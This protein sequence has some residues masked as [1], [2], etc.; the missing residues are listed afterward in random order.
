MTIPPTTVREWEKEFDE[1]Y[2]DKNSPTK[3]RKVNVNH[4][5]YDAFVRLGR[6]ACFTDEQ[7]DFI[8]DGLLHV[9]NDPKS[10]GGKPHICGKVAVHN[11]K[12]S[13]EIHEALDRHSG[14]TPQSKLR[15]WEKEFDENR[16]KTDDKIL[17]FRGDSGCESE[18]YRFGYKYKQDEDIHE[19]TDWGNIKSFIE[20]LLSQ[21][22]KEMVEGIE[23]EIK[24]IDEI[25][26]DHFSDGQKAGLRFALSL[27]KDNPTKQ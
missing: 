22:R 27:L 23:K 20:S 10:L 6:M 4:N 8:W 7:I 2:L 21:Q 26:G 11:T 16:P 25:L 5:V 14:V 3:V 24:D 1:K 13:E 15:E 18:I 19:V 17:D 9:A 12:S